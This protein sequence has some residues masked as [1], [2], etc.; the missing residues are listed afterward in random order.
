MRTGTGRLAHRPAGMSGLAPMALRFLVSF[1]DC[2]WELAGEAVT[3]RPR[4]PHCGDPPSRTS[5]PAS[6]T[7]GSVAEAQEAVAR[8]SRAGQG[9]QALALLLGSALRHALM[10]ATPPGRGTLPITTAW[11]AGPTPPTTASGQIPTPK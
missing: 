6:R 10:A 2:G 9:A 8:I 11:I 7:P 1:E 3:G 4:S 5:A